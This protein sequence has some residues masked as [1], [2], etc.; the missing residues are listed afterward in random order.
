MTAGELLR[1]VRRR[2]GLTQRQLADR[3]RTSQAAISRIERG[4]VSPTVET[5]ATLL[6]L[7]GEELELDA[8]QIDYGHDRTLLQQNLARSPAQRIVFGASFANWVLRNR[9]LANAS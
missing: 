4:V 7:M 2:H 6:D 8:R 1:T 9:G 5:L 3:A